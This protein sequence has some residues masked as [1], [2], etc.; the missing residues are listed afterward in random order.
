MASTDTSTSDSRVLAAPNTN[1][2]IS[3]DLAVAKTVQ[4]ARQQQV[5]RILTLG[6]GPWI[7]RTK[8]WLAAGDFCPDGGHQ[9]CPDL[10]GFLD[11]PSKFREVC[12]DNWTDLQK[13]AKNHQKSPKNHRPGICLDS[14]LIE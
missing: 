3:M 11:R 10:S 9:I 8:A 1:G 14:L 12:P 13:M 6:L 4:D 2:D 7:I 5:A